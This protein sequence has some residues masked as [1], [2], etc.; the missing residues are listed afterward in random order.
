[1]PQDMALAQAAAQ[2]YARSRRKAELEA[3]DSE[4]LVG[5][6]GM[7]ED[8]DIYGLCRRGDARGLRQLLDQWAFRDVPRAESVLEEL[9]RRHRK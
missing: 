1:M 4:R 5:G 9:A 2:E 7:R 8:D 3:A 6:T